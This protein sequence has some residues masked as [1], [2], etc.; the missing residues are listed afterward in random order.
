MTED[1]IDTR[2]QAF[3]EYD[4]TLELSRFELPNIDLLASHGSGK[5]EVSHE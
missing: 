4:P 5:T 2:V 1:E 3:G